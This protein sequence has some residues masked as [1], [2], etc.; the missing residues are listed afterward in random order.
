M[1]RITLNLTLTFC[2]I[3]ISFNEMMAQNAS[4]PADSTTLVKPV[5][6][7]MF[8]NPSFYLIGGLFLIMLIVVIVLTRTITHMAKSITGYK[9]PVAEE[10]PVG[11]ERISL[12]QRFDRA[13]L[14]KA[15]PIEKEKDI[16]FDH[17]YDG[18]Y[19]LDNDL[20]PWWKYGFYLTIFFA[21][22]YLINYHVLKTGKLQL[23]EYNQ[24]LADADAEQKARMAKMVN[25]ITE[26]NVIALK[27]DAS[28]TAGKETFS[29]NCVAC[30][31][32]NGEGLV[33]PNFTDQYWIHGGG[34]KNIFKVITNGVPAKGMIS[35]KSQLSPKQIQEV[36][37]YILTFQGTKPLNGKEP[38]GAIWV[39]PSLQTDS[40][41][42]VKSDSAIISAVV[43]SI[44]K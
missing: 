40:T 9:E 43:D 18:I 3:L 13:V 27:D 39:D 5:F 35:W 26:E 38:Q 10:I 4:A 31:G 22:V 34:I 24:E 33:G 17:E 12:W 8:A 2:F 6:P 7:E 14:T 23:A 15:V 30:H 11:V 21:F 42:T 20:P 36:G 37:S 32:A 1:K 41:S 19:E 28:I 16:M 25:F 29:K 44:K